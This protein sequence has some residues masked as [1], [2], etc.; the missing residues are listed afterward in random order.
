M[1]AGASDKMTKKGGGGEER[2][3]E[4]ERTGAEEEEELRGELLVI[5]RC[6]KKMQQVSHT[7]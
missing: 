5:L 1:C 7:G 6:I 2:R 3:K 4:R